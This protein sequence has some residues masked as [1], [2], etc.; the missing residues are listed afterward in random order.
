[1][2][3]K[4]SGAMAPEGTDSGRIYHGE[5]VAVGMLYMAE[6][7][8]KERIEEVLKKYGLP[9]EDPFSVDEL[10]EFASHDKKKRDG[11]VKLVK[12]DEIGSFSFK[13]ASPEELRNI[14]QARKI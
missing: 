4:I 14:I 5:A 10:M 12:V 7:E 6:G 8:A 13:E 1:M 9:T 2:R 11:K 3:A